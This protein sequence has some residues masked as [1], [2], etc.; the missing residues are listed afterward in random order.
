MAVT[1]RAKRPG[2]PDPR[3][4]IVEWGAAAG[5]RAREVEA[6]HSSQVSRTPLRE[7][8]HD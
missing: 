5:E 6:V 4:E 7:A 1:Q 8:L 2:I 3:D